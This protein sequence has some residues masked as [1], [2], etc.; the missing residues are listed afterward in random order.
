[1]SAGRS[2]SS[3]GRRSA[4]DTATLLRNGV[5]ALAGLGIAGTVVELVFLRHWS[6]A[7]ATIVWVGVVALG[8]G[9]GG[10]LRRPTA[11]RIRAVRILAAAG[12]VVSLLGIGF[13]VLENLDAGPLDRAFAARWATMSAVDQW[14][15]AIT[16]GVGPAPTLAPGALAEISLA[17]L[18]TTVRHP[19]T[20]SAS[21]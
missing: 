18:L 11:T 12:L 19:A 13:H 17:L 6:S 3:W 1:M 4:R 10:L 9:F 2:S 8:A 20:L 14:F 7:T 5:L 15:T 21:V 16:G